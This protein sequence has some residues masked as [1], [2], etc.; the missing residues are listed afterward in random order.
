MNVVCLVEKIKNGQWLVLIPLVV[1]IPIR[2]VEFF[3]YLFCMFI[4]GFFLF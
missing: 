4:Y 3:E 2:I 1:N